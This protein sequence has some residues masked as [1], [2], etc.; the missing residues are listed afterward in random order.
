MQKREDFKGSFEGNIRLLLIIGRVGKIE[1]R[2][3]WRFI[4]RLFFNLNLYPNVTRDINR[5][6]IDKRNM[7]R[8][9]RVLNQRVGR[10]NFKG[11]S[12]IKR[13]DFEKQNIEFSSIS[14]WKKYNKYHVKR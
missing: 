4:V 1:N 8:T 5:D 9:C 10:V 11:C 6:K 13:I 2:F 7:E 14:L 3:E 12:R